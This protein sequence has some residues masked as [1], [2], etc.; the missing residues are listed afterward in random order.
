MVCIADEFVCD[1][2][3]AI[4]NTKKCDGVN[5]CKGLDERENFCD[6]VKRRN[7]SKFNPV[8]SP[9]FHPIETPT[10]R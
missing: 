1:G 10:F 2:A 5:D 3:T 6:M 7:E 9:D 4:K 8:N